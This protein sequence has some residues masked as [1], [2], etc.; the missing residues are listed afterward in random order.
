TLE[1]PLDRL[2]PALQR[3]RLWAEAQPRVEEASRDEREWSDDLFARLHAGPP[4]PPH[5]LGDRPL[6][7]LTRAH[8]RYP[9]GLDVPAAELEGERLAQQAGL[10]FLSRNSRQVV[11]EAGHNMHLEDPA[12]V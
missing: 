7:V 5:P 9:D 10:A 8:G 3:L 2:P 12:L 4:P 11:A 1:P 6:I